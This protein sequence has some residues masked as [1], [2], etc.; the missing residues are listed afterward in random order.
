[1]MKANI[2]EKNGGEEISTFGDEGTP[3]LRLKCRPPA[4]GYESIKKEPKA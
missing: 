2:K 4:Y 3:A 1:M